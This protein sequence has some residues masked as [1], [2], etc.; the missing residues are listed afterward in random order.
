MRTRGIRSRLVILLTA[1]AAAAAVPSSSSPAAA[2]DAAVCGPAAATGQSTITTSDG[3]AH[4]YHWRVPE[5]AAP[6][7]GRPVLVWL[8]GDGGN[9]SGLAQEFW[10]HTDPDGAI[11]VTP[12]GTGGT[13]NH[14][15]G[16]TP[17]TPQDSQFLSRV[18]DE[19][20]ACPTV[21]PARI[22]VGGVSR[23]AYMPYYLLQR[24]STR[25]RIAAVAV[26]AGLLYC[27]EGDASCASDE[28]DAV[29]HS[30]GARMIHLHGT[31]DQAVAPPP[32]AAYH[33]PVD[34]DVD[35]RVFAPM[36]LWAEQDGC[37][38]W[39][40]GGPNNGVLRETFQAGGKTAR[41]YDLSGHGARCAKYRLVLVTDGGHVIDGQEERIWSFLHDGPGEVPDPEVRCD[42]AAATLVGT[43]AADELVGTAGADVVAGLGGTDT[44]RGLGGGDTVC[45]GSGADVL[46]GGAGADR[47]LGGDGNDRLVGGGGADALLGQDWWDTLVAKDG[48]V[49]RQINCGA[50]EDPPARRDAK[51]P[52]AVSC[53]S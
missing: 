35:W 29:L 49:D 3:Q 48:V 20:L 11:V 43:A 50:G 7:S 34:W 13:W 44:I 52:R 5:T 46:L 23:G 25:D 24:P 39:T 18:L 1:T 27:Q 31:D 32:T 36:K 16:D 26:N 8:H 22:Y 47:L 14:R 2:A 21:D 6:A 51:D 12:N 33:D 4:T 41:V 30:S 10:P 15:A 45:G 9:G 53:T 17:G 40:T 19:L 42:G 28:S 37:W 38:T